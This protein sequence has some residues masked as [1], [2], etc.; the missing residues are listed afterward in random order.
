MSI[1]IELTKQEVAQ[2]KHLTQLNGD[3]DAVG[4]AVRAFLRVS[5]LRQLK[6]ASGKIEFVYNWQD[7]EALEVRECTI[8]Q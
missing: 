7:L 2:I 5:R 3:A 6:T 8:P 1:T 4:L